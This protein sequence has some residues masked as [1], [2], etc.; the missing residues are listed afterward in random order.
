MIAMNQLVNKIESLPPECLQ[1]L[2]D[3][4]E[5]LRLKHLKSIPETMILSEKSL[6]EYW[7]TPE[8]DEAWA[9]L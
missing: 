8:E 1:E 3:F 2:M 9:D 7:D 4:V 5:Y 6:A